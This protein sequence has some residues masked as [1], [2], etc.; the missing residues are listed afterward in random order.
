[1]LECM[2]DAYADLIFLDSKRSE[3]ERWWPT[4][5][6]VLRKGGL[7]V[8]DNATSHADEMGPFMALVSGDADATTCTVPVGNGQFLATRA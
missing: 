5:K 6:R 8:V 2:L 1:M 3:Y 4:I 7:L